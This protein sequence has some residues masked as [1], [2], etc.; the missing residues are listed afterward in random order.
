MNNY[1]FN[2]ESRSD[3]GKGA[4][5]RLRHTNS[6][7]AIIYGGGGEAQSLTINHDDVIKALE[8]EAVYTSILTVNIDGKANKAIIKDIQR[9]AY[10]PKVLHMDFQRVSENEKIH[11]H[12]PIHFLGGDS[13]PGV[14]AGGQMTHNMSDIEVACLAK[15]LPEYLEIDVSGMELGDTLHISDLALPQGVVSVELSH[16]S[17]HDQPIVAIHKARGMSD[18][19]AGGETPDAAEAPSEE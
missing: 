7:P 16:G 15:D 1:T 12:V 19:E 5:R 2:T 13:A 17:D 8:N 14:K 6:I 10:K 18:E 4:S 9:H 3:T 11:M